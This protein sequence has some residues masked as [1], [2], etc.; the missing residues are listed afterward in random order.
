MAILN[1]LRGRAGL[2]AALALLGC[3]A[4][5]CALLEVFT[6]K[7]FV[8]DHKV[9]LNPDLPLECGSCHAGWENSDQP[10]MPSPGVC[11]LCHDARD[12]DKPPDRKVA[13]LFDGE[14]YKAQRVAKLGGDVKFSHQRH[15]TSPETCSACH[16]G[17]ET[18]TRVDGSLAVSMTACVDC[19]GQQ[20]IA[21]ECATCHDR[22]RV[23]VAPDS[24]AFQWQRLHGPTP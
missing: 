20:K 18:N 1:V 6:G 22:I 2:G 17:I 4:A 3:L 9:H 15:A 10:G 14:V 24:H 12:K 8:F 7:P 13:A 19:H 11:A 21:N 23:D 5:G 16:R